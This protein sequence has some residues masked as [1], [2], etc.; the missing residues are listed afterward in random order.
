M[1]LWNGGSGWRDRRSSESENLDVRLRI[2]LS[3]SLSLSS[4][5]YTL[6]VP[7]IE[8]TSV[9]SFPSLDRQPSQ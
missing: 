5:S 9:R 4:L 2:F 1:N 6:G 3:L 8:I 7:Q